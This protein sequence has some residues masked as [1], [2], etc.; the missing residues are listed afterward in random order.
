MLHYFGGLTFEETAAALGISVPTV[1][2]EWRFTRSWLFA[3]MGGEKT[4][5]D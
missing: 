3:R 5:P 4:E 1:Q 2:R